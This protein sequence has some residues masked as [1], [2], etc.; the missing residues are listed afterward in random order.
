M[1]TQSIEIVKTHANTFNA[2][3]R[4]LVSMNLEGWTA[5][6]AA[7]FKNTLDS[8]FPGVDFVMING[9]VEGVMPAEPH[10]FVL[11]L[12]LH[13][14]RTFCR[15][16]GIQPHARTT[17][18]ITSEGAARGRQLRAGDVIHALPRLPQSLKDAWAVVETDSPQ[19]SAWMTR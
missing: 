8:R 9:T 7:T 10:T 12:T 13:E 15:E 11:A 14:G 3:D 6:D 19:W 1:S 4:V 16:N 18:I 5:E 2:G 17:H